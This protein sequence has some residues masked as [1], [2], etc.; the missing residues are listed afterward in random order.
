MP[1]IKIDQADRLFSIYIRLRDRACQRCGS[2]VKFNAKGLP[3]S[4]ENSHYFGRRAENTRFEPKNCDTLCM[5]CH[6]LWGGKNFEDY[7]WFKINQ[8]GQEEFDKLLLAS[9]TYRKKDRKLEAIFWREQLK[10]LT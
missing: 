4:H 9:N 10:E 2:A 3:V 5:G 1:K 8:L 6:M 7:R